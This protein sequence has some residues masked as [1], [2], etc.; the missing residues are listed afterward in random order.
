M[1]VSLAVHIA[2][3]IV[4]V[5]GMFF[6]LIVLRPA[7]GPLEPAARIALWRG[8]F[9]RFFPWVWASVAGLMASGYGMIHLLGGFA[10]VG[11][12]IHVMHA[13][14]LIMTGLF[15]YLY[16]GSWRGFARAAREG[17]PAVAAPFL[18]R[19]RRIVTI[20]LALGLI[21]ALIGATGRYWA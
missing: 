18:D 19:I 12:H 3:A 2:A 9:S 7:A 17:A 1:I 14:G 13:L 11:V 8:V 16:F 15:A 6:A 5:G 20:N 10:A 4:W 21:T